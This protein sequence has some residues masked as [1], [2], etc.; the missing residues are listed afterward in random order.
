MF[1]SSF[2]SEILDPHNLPTNPTRAKSF[3]GAAC[4]KKF[5]VVRAPRQISRGFLATTQ[6]SS[7][8]SASLIYPCLLAPSSFLSA[9]CSKRATPDQTCGTSWCFLFII[10]LENLEFSSSSSKH[11]GGSALA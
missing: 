9:P 5:A 3:P 4:L 8:P 10:I 11:H 1:C 2:R 6:S 7:P